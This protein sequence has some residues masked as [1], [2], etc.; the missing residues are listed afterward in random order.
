M[1]RCLDDCYKSAFPCC[2]LKN[3]KKLKK[4][5]EKRIERGQEEKAQKQKLKDHFGRMHRY[6]YYLEMMYN[7]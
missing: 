4:E 1:L 5:E 6:F 3:K 7:V 2:I